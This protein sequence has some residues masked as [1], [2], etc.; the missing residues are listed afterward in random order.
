MAPEE[1]PDRPDQPADGI[2]Q[3]LVEFTEKVP[4]MI[5]DGAVSLGFA[6]V[7]LVTTPIIASFKQETEHRPWQSLWLAAPLGVLVWLLL[8]S[9]PGRSGFRPRGRHL[10]LLMLAGCL[11]SAV[12]LTRGC[13][14]PRVLG[15]VRHYPLPRHGAP[16]FGD[17]RYLLAPG[18]PP[19]SRIAIL[20][21]PPLESTMRRVTLTNVLRALHRAGATGVALDYSF[22]ARTITPADAALASG[23]NEF[24]GNSNP[25]VAGLPINRNDFDELVRRPHP[26]ALDSLLSVMPLGHLLAYREADGRVRAMPIRL[27]EHPDRP[28]FSLLIASKLSGKPIDEIRLPRDG[29]LQFLRPASD[30]P[31]VTE[32]ELLAPDP[33]A[34]RDRLRGQFVMIGEASAAES[35]DTAYGRKLGV[36]VQSWAVNSLLTGRFIERGAWWVPM[37]AIWMSAFLLTSLA[38]LGRT[39]RVIVATA[40]VLCLAATILSAAAMAISLFWIDLVH[41]WVAILV[42]TLILLIVPRPRLL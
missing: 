1:K 31:I 28:C 40:V 8:Q 35:C 17:W 10:V 9:P 26:P 42:L 29:V 33:D 23:L 13:D 5:K 19:D 2:R 30:F 4:G 32:A 20:T 27:K 25:I 36:E 21:V 18:P 12:I 16:R 14:T 24:V 41:F 11:S 37:A 15:A 39:R 6:L 22:D 38:S 7:T 3:A 34:A